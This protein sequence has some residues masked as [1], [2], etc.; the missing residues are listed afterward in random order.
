LF[1]RPTA[2]TKGVSSD[3]ITI[4]MDASIIGI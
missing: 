4:E 3:Y 1:V 2:N